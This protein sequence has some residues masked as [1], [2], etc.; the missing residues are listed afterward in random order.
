MGEI[1]RQL[2][3]LFGLV[4]ILMSLLVDKLL[5]SVYFFMIA[6]FFLV[7]SYYVRREKTLLAR[8]AER[9]ENGF[10]DFANSFE[11][12]TTRIP[13][14]GAFWFYFSCGL[15][16]LLFPVQTAV[17][18]CSILAVS[19]SLSTIMGS[20]FGTQRIV[21][22]KTL[23]RS[24]FFFISAFIVAFL[25]INFWAALLAA[26]TSTIAELLPEMRMFGVLRNRE[27]INDNLTVPLITALL[28]S[29]IL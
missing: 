9:V 2:V 22:N 12:E 3:H 23:E 8:L 15:T 13:Y 1:G 26:L 21:G 4:F 11:R 17:V 28:L 18:A 29:F 19:D 5:I 10:R 20:R 14:S 6:S 24:T 27:L 16:L 7:Y 25:F